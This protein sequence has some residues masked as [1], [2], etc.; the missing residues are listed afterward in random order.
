M[1]LITIIPRLLEILNFNL[2][3]HKGFLLFK[4]NFIIK[5]IFIFLGKYNY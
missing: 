4:V 3:Y 2:T 1:S 5:S